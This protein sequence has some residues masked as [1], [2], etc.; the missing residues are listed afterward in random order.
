MLLFFVKRSLFWECRCAVLPLLLYSE[1][2][3]VPPPDEPQFSHL[4]THP[5]SPHRRLPSETPALHQSV[6]SDTSTPSFFAACAPCPPD[7]RGRTWKSCDGL[8]PPQRRAE[9]PIKEPSSPF[10]V[11]DMHPTAPP[12]YFP[13]L[14]HPCM[15]R[16]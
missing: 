1:T 11:L 2:P 15:L 10:L 13:H 7:S 4:T 3:L 5:Y 14:F 6:A 12:L 9:A 16:S 8:F